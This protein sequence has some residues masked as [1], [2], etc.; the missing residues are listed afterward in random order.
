MAPRTHIA[1][2]KAQG[3]GS[4]GCGVAEM[5]R[6]RLLLAASEVIGQNGLDAASVGAICSYAGVSRRTFYDLFEHR[7]A[8][9]L[10]ALKDGVERL[11]RCLLDRVDAAAP[12]ESRMRAGLMALLERL[13]GEPSLARMCLIEALK[14]SPAVLAY[15]RQVLDELVAE[16]D[17]GRLGCGREVE[18]VALTAESIVGGVLA[19]LHARL[20]EHDRPS[21]IAMLNP[22]MSMIVQPYRGSSA[23]KRERERPK[24]SSRPRTAGVLSAS[25]RV[26]R[27]PFKGLSIRLTYRTARVLEMIDAQPGASN[28]QVGEAAGVHDQGQISRLLHR[29]QR[30]GLIANQGGDQ[31]KGG[32]NAWRLTERGRAI[33]VTINAAQNAA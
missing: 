28:R 18:P 29:L 14:G 12:W 31:A 2:P 4:P 16:V 5:Q 9:L 6:R 8:C 1:E 22:L 33:H 27:D 3:L 25:A 30:N 17:R 24:P 20:F 11:R 23:A 10:A 15:R 26:G 19:V 21:L 13:D 7:E 32:A